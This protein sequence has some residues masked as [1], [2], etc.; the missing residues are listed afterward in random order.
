MTCLRILTA[1]RAFALAAALAL[2]TVTAAPAHADDPLPAPTGLEVLHVA[3]TTAE[4]DWSSACY[5]TGDVVQR[6]LNGS[7]QTYATGLC[8]YLPLTG[9][10]PGLKYTF[11]VYSAA[12]PDIGYSQSPPSAAISFTTLSGPDSVPPSQPG[13]PT[14]SSITTTSAE[15]FWGQSTDNVQ[16][17][18]YYLQQLVNGTWTTIRTVSAS[19]NYQYLS[20]LSPASSYTYAAIAFDARGNMSQRSNPATLT[21][22]ALTQKP[23]CKVQLQVYWT[24]F[25][26]TATIVNSTA[27]AISG[28]T[29]GFSLSPAATVS[30]VFG[31][32]LTRTGGSG[33]ITPASYNGTVGPGGQLYFGFIGSA[34]PP[35]PP[36][37]FTFNG[38][39]CT[40][41]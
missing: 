27:A 7:W 39:P 18:G 41:A 30:N 3:D 38:L 36:S 11:R 9:L 26:A 28:W 10:T 37:G 21:T 5:S 12:V 8:D 23:S 15:I 24:G 31:G 16:V 2:A 35:A 33:T 4:M 20:G 40:A 6:Y 14:F 22:L 13:T 32:V 17:T 29:F 34:S 25:T 19:G 1:T